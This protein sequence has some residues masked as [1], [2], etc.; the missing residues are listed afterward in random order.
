MYFCTLEI[1]KNIRDNDGAVGK[2]KEVKPQQAL[3]LLLERSMSLN[4]SSAI[5]QLMAFTAWG[6]GVFR[7]FNL[8]PYLI[9]RT[10]I[11]PKN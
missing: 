7:R 1:T 2:P 5:C 6:G 3:L 8:G 9:P 10:T 4:L 11:I